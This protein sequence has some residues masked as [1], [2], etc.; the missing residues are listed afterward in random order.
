MG[1]LIH[2]GIGFIIMRAEDL[3][4]VFRNK[5]NSAIEAAMPIIANELL[6][7]KRSYFSE[8]GKEGWE[9]L[10]PQTITKKT[11][12]FP[13]NA[14]KFNIESGFLRDSIRINYRLHQNELELIVEAQHQNGDEAIIQLIDVYGRDFLRFDAKEIEFIRKRL[15]EL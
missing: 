8:Q 11:R 15:G 5:I 6:E 12:K 1:S 10:R 3:E 4:A 9:P 14:T 2:L 13:S 7:I